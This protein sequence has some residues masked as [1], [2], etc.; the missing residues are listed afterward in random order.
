MKNIFFFYNINSNNFLF[1]KI[2]EKTSKNLPITLTAPYIEEESYWKEACLQ[3]WNKTHVIKLEMHGMLW[4]NAYLE[5][6]LKE[7]LENIEVYSIF[8]QF[9]YFFA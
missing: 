5:N 3:R 6:H 7:Y 2:I 8:L 9:S 1:V 4:K